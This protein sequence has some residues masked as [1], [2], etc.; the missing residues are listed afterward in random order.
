MDTNLTDENSEVV[1]FECSEEMYSILE[2]ISKEI[3]LSYEE[4]LITAL[5]FLIQNVQMNGGNIHADYCP[6]VAA[7]VEKRLQELRNRNSNQ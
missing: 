7:K 4:T 5:D 2:S 1:H 3:G 6:E